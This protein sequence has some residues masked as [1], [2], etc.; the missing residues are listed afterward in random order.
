MNPSRHQ[1]YRLRPLLGATPDHPS[2]RHATNSFVV[3]HR[4]LAIAPPDPIT[5]ETLPSPST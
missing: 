5:T 4:T 2:L 1:L 3:S